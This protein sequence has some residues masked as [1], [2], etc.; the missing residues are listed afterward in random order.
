MATILLSAVGGAIGANI[1][2]SV[3]GISAMALGRA[4]GATVGKLLDQRLLGSGAAPVESGKVEQFRIMGSGEGQPMP[5]VF[6]RIR[7]AGQVIWSSRFAENV[8]QTGSGKGGAMGPT[9]RDY[10]YSISLAIGLCEGEVVRIGRVWADGNVLDVNAITMRLYPGDNHQ[11][12]DPAIEA[13]EGAGQAPSYRGTAYVV[14]EDLDL[15]QFGNRIPQFNFE[16]VR[17]GVEDE[18][19]LRDLVQA[20]ALI[21][22][23]GEYAL[24]TEPVN[25]AKTRGSGVMV[26]ANTDTEQ[27]DFTVS[28]AQLNDELPRAAA[29]SLVVSWFGDDLRCDRCKIYPAVEQADIDAGTMPWIVN[30]ITRQQA[31]QVTQTD[32]RP[33]FGGTPSDQ[34]VI[35]AMAALHEAGKSVTFYPFILMDIPQNNT[36]DDPYA[37]G[38]AQPAFPW[39]GRI[40]TSVAA[41]QQGSPEM[42]QD[43]ATEVAAFFGA[44]GVNDFA[45]TGTTVI[46]NGP[47]EFSYR[48]FVLHYAHLCAAAGG[49]DAFLIGSEL[50]GL[51]RIRAGAA[52]FP[53]VAALRVLAGDVRA[54]LGEAVKIGYAAD[55]SE[56]GAYAAGDGDVLFHLDPLWADE[57]IDF[58]GIDNYLPLADWRDTDGHKDSIHGAIYALDYLTQN[59]EGGE[60]FDWYYANQAG[61]DLQI[62]R[63][64]SDGDY[65]EPWI[66][67]AKDIR[68]WW[69]LPHT[70]RLGGVQQ[71][72]YTDWQ[73]Q[74]KP[75]WF[76]E[77]GCPAIDKGANQPN[78]FLDAKSSESVRPYYSNGA[79]DDLMQARYLQ[80]ML[81]YWGDAANNPE[82]PHYLGRM[83]DMTRAHVWAWDMRPWPAF[84]ANS[85]LWS[86]AENHATGHWLNGRV[87]QVSLAQVVREI[88]AYSGQGNCD[89][90]ALY[91]A[92]KGYTLRGD[93]SAREAL[94]PLMLAHGFDVI[95]QAGVFVFRSRDGATRF[96]LA[97]EGLAVDDETD[98]P[99]QY[100]RG[101]PGPARVR[102]SYLDG[103]NDYQAGAAEAVQPEATTP[104]VSHT[105]LDMVLGSDQAQVIAERWLNEGRVARDV[106][107]FALPPSQA[108]IGA[109]DVVQLMHGTTS[110]RYRIDRIEEMGLR[111]VSAVRVEPGV[112]HAAPATAR[113]HAKAG[114]VAA[115]PVF[116]MLLDLPLLAESDVAQHPYIAVAADPWPGPVT[117]YSSAGDSGYG[118]AGSLTRG[119]ILGRTQ[120]DLPAS[121]PG[122]WA[123]GKELQVVLDTGALHSASATDVLNGANVAALRT[124]AGWEV[125]Q[126]QTAELIAPKTYRLGM[127]LRGQAG[128]DAV[129]Q[130][131]LS[132][133]ADFVAL[134]GVTQ[135]ALATALIGAERHYRVGPA[136]RAYDSGRYHHFTA[137]HLGVGLRPYAPV[138]LR[139]SRKEDGGL[140]FKWLRRGRIE[141]DSWL[142]TDIPLAEETEA[143]QVRILSG[144]TLRRD[145]QSAVANWQYSAAMQAEDGVFSPFEIEIAQLSA[146][147]GAGLVARKTIHV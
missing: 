7:V 110:A 88:C 94:Q 56:Y 107:S 100:H 28:L 138:H 122:R 80:A 134:D 36:L 71:A 102:V 74:S 139:E 21:P 15:T 16:V 140:V 120:S 137:T 89:T 125:F 5:R 11:M 68:S 97:T 53:A 72:T 25:L 26:N 92:V 45:V 131:V 2:G 104:D 18:M 46:Y 33:N 146:S 117:V 58:I 95:E 113:R 98:Q 64:I 59:V 66:Y 67:R 54:I 129:M 128:T 13:I 31:A 20:V 10:T 84:P 65:N 8:S 118:L 27:S 144:G 4:A 96:E 81:G 111:K 87:A 39:R 47:E 103:D 119:A 126:F 62:R 22:G 49:V 145:V 29:T 109:G 123:R 85:E 133:G 32:A 108:A 41:G 91:G 116:G 78:V 121:A 57:N 44:A 3:L 115:G 82:S 141:N 127:L 34:S 132:A 106:A 61:R 1:G 143:Y 90:A 23:S 75:I 142:G 50:R 6:G 35:Q 37:P 9:R 14:F 12:P 135:I 73:P 60:Y 38:A 105:G 55:W 63:P 51:T 42:T 17:P 130:D 79:A 77:L 86:D 93:E 76:T 48:R 99:L 69:S 136:D 24:A 124:N 147:F 30:G 19:A 70:N 83:I 43:A 114:A 101:P 40:T 52:E 112:Y